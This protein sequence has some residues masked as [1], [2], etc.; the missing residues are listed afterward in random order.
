MVHDLYRHLLTKL[1]YLFTF[2]LHF[3]LSFYIANFQKIRFSLRRK[4]PAT[5]TPWD[6]CAPN[7]ILVLKSIVC[8]ARDQKDRQRVWSQMQMLQAKQVRVGGTKAHKVTTGKDKEEK[9]K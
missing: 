7:A 9:D 5:V 2:N 8:L 3:I 6:L 4:N 1:V